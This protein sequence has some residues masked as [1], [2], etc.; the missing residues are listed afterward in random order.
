MLDF[1]HSQWISK[2]TSRLSS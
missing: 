2:R 1:E